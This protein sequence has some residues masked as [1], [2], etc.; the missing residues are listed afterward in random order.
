MGHLIS[1]TLLGS[2]SYISES[3][4]PKANHITPV[5]RRNNEI[6]NCTRNNINL[7]QDKQH[8]QDLLQQLENRF[9]QLESHVVKPEKKFNKHEKGFETMNSV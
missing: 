2:F 7:Q 9:N 1:S 6:H 3:T 5:S 4:L 8:W